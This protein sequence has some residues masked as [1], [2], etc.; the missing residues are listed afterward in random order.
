MTKSINVVKPYTPQITAWVEDALVSEYLFDCW[1]V[2]GIS[3]RM[4]GSCE[5]ITVMVHDAELRS[6]ANVFGVV[7]RDFRETNEPHWMD[8]G[9][10]IRCFV[11]PVHEIENYLLDAEAL[12]GC[13]ANNRGRSQ[14]GIEA[15]MKSR[16]QQLVWWMA[17]RYTIK[18]ISRTCIDGFLDTPNPARSSIGPVPPGISRATLGSRGSPAMLRRSPILDTSG[19]GL[20]RPSSNMRPT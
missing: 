11:L 2:P 14:A 4:G 13:D 9:R 5:S 8:M 20:T 12:A 18:R 1:N 16:A 6:E 17:C 19:R 7:D 3:C 10:E 15:R